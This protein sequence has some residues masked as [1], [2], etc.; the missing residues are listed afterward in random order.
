HRVAPAPFA[1][2]R[3]V[4]RSAPIV[5]AGAPARTLYLVQSGQVRTYLVTAQ[6]GEVTTA[7]LG[8]GELLGISAL[9][10]GPSYRASCTALTDAELWELA[11]DRLREW[12]ARDSDLAR[13]VLEALGRR[14]VL[15]EQLLRQVPLEPMARRIPNVLTLLEAH[16]GGQ[17]PHLTREM[18]AGLVGVRRET[19][20]RAI[21]ARRR[22][23]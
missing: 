8:E 19:V 9:L 18:L 2:L 7:V 4:R 11:A 10:G 5:L 1:V 17:R 6:G 3:R 22:A 15:A 20:S 13:L 14:L 12:L 21:V 16:L 23:D